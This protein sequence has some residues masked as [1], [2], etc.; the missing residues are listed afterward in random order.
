MYN[1]V[2]VDD[3]RIVREGMTSYFLDGESGFTVIKSFG[4]GEEAFEYLKENINE[5]DVVLTDITM[6]KMSGLELVKKLYE[7]KADIQTILLTGYKEFEYAQ[8]AVKYGVYRYLLKP[9]KFNELDEVFSELREK[10]D[11][12]TR[13]IFSNDLQDKKQILI[14]QFLIELYSGYF[15]DE[16]IMLDRIKQLRI[17]ESFLKKPCVIADISRDVEKA[18]E[19]DKWKYDEER[20]DIAIFNAVRCENVEYYTLNSDKNFLKIIAVPDYEVEWESFFFDIKECIVHGI[21][22]LKQ[23]FSI[24]IEVNETQNFDNIKNL[25]YS[26]FSGS[27]D[28]QQMLIN[29][30]IDNSAILRAIKYV[31]ENYKKNIYISDVAE[32]VGLNQV[33]FGRLFKIC[34]GENFTDYLINLRIEKAMKLL[35]EGNM[36][37]SEVSESVGYDNIK[38]FSRIFKRRTGK[39]PNEYKKERM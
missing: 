23:I 21:E 32:Y 22:N 38:Y 12:K 14:N 30:E 16:K 17:D 28:E 15:D 29:G 36:K 24:N 13:K 27:M 9:V 1:I 35:E 2:V 4:D 6:P 19:D 25:L 18:F 26:C 8:T 5:V 33:Y 20:F 37:I 31:N 39:T 7:E 34:T 3:E 11:E 10:L